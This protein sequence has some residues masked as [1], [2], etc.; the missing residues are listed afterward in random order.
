MTLSQGGLPRLSENCG[1]ATCIIRQVAN[2]LGTWLRMFPPT[3]PDNPPAL[4]LQRRLE[5]QKH[6]DSR[7]TPRSP[8]TLG[9]QTVTRAP[10]G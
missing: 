8:P 3:H 10:L 6:L 5:P 9:L 2:S 7:G 4:C 1:E